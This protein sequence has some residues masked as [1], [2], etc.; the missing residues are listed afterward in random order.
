MPPILAS[1]VN[2]KPWL[3]GL[4]EN[5]GVARTFTTSAL[6]LGS[7]GGPARMRLLNRG[8]LL[9]R[10]RFCVVRMGSRHHIY[11]QKGDPLEL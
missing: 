5:L 8:N 4:A 7:V 10:R 6:G 2:L 11:E 9:N 1:Q 3:S